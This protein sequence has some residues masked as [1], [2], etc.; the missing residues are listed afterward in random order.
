MGHFDEHLVGTCCCDGAARAPP[1][2]LG[3]SLAVAPPDTHRWLRRTG[4]RS[5]SSPAKAS[6][7]CRCKRIRALRSTAPT[8]PRHRF[9]PPTSFRWPGHT[10]RTGA[11]QRG[12]RHLTL[13]SVARNIDDP[14]VV[15]VAVNESTPIFDDHLRAA[16]RRDAKSLAL[17]R[18]RMICS[19]STTQRRSEG[20]KSHNTVVI[21]ECNGLIARLD[22]RCRRLLAI[23]RTVWSQPASI[24]SG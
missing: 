23:A 9:R 13:A 17:R 8:R 18:C 19:P 10:D 3:D 14:H 11:R 5:A 21:L 7:R 2:D 6:Y 15:F 24:S 1:E 22:P 16:W 20:K 12:G 4:C